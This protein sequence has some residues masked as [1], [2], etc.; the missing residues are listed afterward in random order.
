MSEIIIDRRALTAEQ[1]LKL[2][3]LEAKHLPSYK[4][5]LFAAGH[6]EEQVADLLLFYA[7][8]LLIA[9]ARPDLLGHPRF[10][11]TVQ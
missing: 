8:A 3:A 9:V 1:E 5:A 10:A 6:T 2:Q 11:A 4:S 7:D